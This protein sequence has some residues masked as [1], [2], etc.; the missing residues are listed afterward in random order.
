M[1][2]IRKDSSFL[3]QLQDRIAATAGGSR[4]GVLSTGIP[5]VDAA[6]P[7]QGLALGAVHEWIGIEHNAGRWVPPLALLTA[8]ANLAGGHTVWIGDAVWPYPASLARTNTGRPPPLSSAMFV[9]TQTRNERLWAADVALRSRAS[10]AVIIDGSG[11]DLA[12]TRRLQLAAEAGGAL[13]LLARAPKELQQLSTA[14][15][16]WRIG[17]CPQGHARQWEIELIRC[18]S[19]TSA[20]TRRWVV[21]YDQTTGL[22]HLASNL[23]DRSCA[24]TLGVQ[25]RAG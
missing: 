16:R 14:S 18:K 7:A 1:N 15:T 24:P 5:S 10:K 23:F 22:M 17:W 8:M 25:T 4:L 13:C 2:G 6:L 21:E 19:M 12:A 3:Q 11:F 9:R 20:R